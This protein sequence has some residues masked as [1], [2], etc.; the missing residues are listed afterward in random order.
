MLYQKSEGSKPTCP[1]SLKIQ[2]KES[3]KRVEARVSNAVLSR[4][5]RPRSPELKECDQGCRVTSRKHTSNE[6]KEHEKGMPTCPKPRTRKR[7]RVTTSKP[8]C[9]KENR[10]DQPSN[11]PNQKREDES[12]PDSESQKINSWDQ[13]Q[14]ERNLT[15][16]LSRLPPPMRMP[17]L[18]LS[19]PLNFQT[20][21][22]PSHAITSPVY[23]DPPL[24]ELKPQLLKQLRINI[25][26][27]LVAPHARVH[28]LDARDRIATLRVVNADGGAAEG[29]VV[30]VGAVVHF[31]V[32]DGDDV[33]TRCGGYVAGGAGG[34]GGGGVVGK[35]TMIGG[36][37]GD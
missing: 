30:G 36:G 26:R 21:L 10:K 1:V 2:P 35:V 5:I 23:S 16:N 15:T 22:L 24:G 11:V 33:F 17:Q 34:V 31:Q 12:R 32:G 14:P 8:A 28:N 3:S 9:S 27:L 20:P 37:E 6:P 19:Y 29:V 7:K 13:D 4:K 18:S 25:N